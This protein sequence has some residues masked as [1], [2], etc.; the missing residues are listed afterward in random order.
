MRPPVLR[1]SFYELRLVPKGASNVVASRIYG[2]STLSG[3]GNDVLG[4]L[5][6]KI[7]LGQVKCKSERIGFV[8]IG[9]VNINKYAC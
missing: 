6:Q 1:K 5:G 8:S 3:E 4:V 2:P 9:N 7:R